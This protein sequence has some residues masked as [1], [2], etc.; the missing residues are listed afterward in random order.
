[1]PRSRNWGM[2]ASGFNTNV[3]LSLNKIVCGVQQ[4][5]L[6]DD[7]E[8]KI[9]TQIIP[10]AGDLDGK[11]SGANLERLRGDAGDGVRVHFKGGSWGATTVPS[12]PT[13]TFFVSKKRRM[14]R[15]SSKTGTF[16]PSTLLGH[17]ARPAPKTRALTPAMA[18]EIT[19]TTTRAVIM[20][21]RRRNPLA[22]DFSPGCL[23]LAYLALSFI[24]WLVFGWATT[25]MARL[26]LTRFLLLTLYVR[27]LLYF[28]IWDL[29]LLADASARLLHPRRP[30]ARDMLLFKLRHDD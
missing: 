1:M 29:V 20:V 17:H 12:M 10:V 13:L 3:F 21:I 30:V 4:I 24:L 9:T 8:K 26:T 11:Q 5:S 2:L 19:T 22:G 6:D 23:S 16:I 27:F 7:K 18:A 15:L 28:A 14:S 25:A